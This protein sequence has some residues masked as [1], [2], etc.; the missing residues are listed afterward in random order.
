MLVCV[1]PPPPLSARIFR[2]R[3]LQ[4]SRV[5]KIPSPKRGGR[6]GSLYLSFLSL[7]GRIFFVENLSSETPFHPRLFTPRYF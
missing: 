7:E 3:I 2:F 6:E 1:S 4:V 5:M